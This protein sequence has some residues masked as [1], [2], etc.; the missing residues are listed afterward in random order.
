[1]KIKQ[2]IAVFVVIF[3]INSVIAQDKKYKVHTVA[4]YN[5]ENLFDKKMILMFLTKNIHQHKD[6]RVINTN[7]N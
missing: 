1:M 3:A 6:G 5:L 2:L 7:K 4:F